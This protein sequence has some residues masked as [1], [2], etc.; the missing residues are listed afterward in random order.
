MDTSN[1]G[2]M[3]GVARQ[4]FCGKC[5]GYHKKSDQVV[6]KRA[7][8]HMENQKLKEEKRLINGQ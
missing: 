1:R 6:N 3:L 7:D 5:C 4:P 8:R 2:R